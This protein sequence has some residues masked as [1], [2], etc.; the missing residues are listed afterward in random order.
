MR[1]RNTRRLCRVIFDAFTIMFCAAFL[2][3]S[4]AAAAEPEQ[5]TVRVGY[6]NAITYEEKRDDGYMSGAGYEYLQKISYI[7]GWNYEYVYGSF[8]ECYEMLINGDIDLFG[9]LTYTPERAE[10]FSF[11]TYP[12][13]QEVYCMYTNEAHAALEDGGADGLNGCRIG[14]TAG[15]YQQNI[16][17]QWLDMNHVQAE[18]VPLSGYNALMQ[19]L[20]SDQVDTIVTPDLSIAY[21]CIPLMDVGSS[22]YF[23][24]VSKNRPDLLKEL[25]NAQREI[26]RNEFDYN[27]ALSRKYHSQT[28]SSLELSDAE[29]KWLAQR[30][31]Q[32]SIGLLDHNLPYSAQ[33]SNGEAN[34]ILSVLGDTMEQELGVSVQ[35]KFYQN[36]ASLL[37][38]MQNGEVDAIA[39]I[40]GDLYLAEQSRY[41]LTNAI[42]KTTP[43]VLYAGDTFDLDH[44]VIAV[45]DESLITE[46][47]IQILYPGA[48]TYP[49]RNLEDCLNAVVSG[50]A[51]GTVVTSV[52]LNTLRQ[53]PAMEK[54]QFTDLPLEAEICLATTKGNRMAAAVLNTG[55]ALSTASL[56]G[57]MLAQ[58]SYVAPH[59]SLW[60][61]VKD[62]MAPVLTGT[63]AVILVLLCL[64]F[65]LSY[66]SKRLDAALFSA[67]SANDA[68]TAFLNTMSHDM[69]TPLNAI[70]GLTELAQKED[71]FGIVREYLDKVSTSGKFL[72]GLINDL[73]DISKIESGGLKLNPAP[74]TKK[75]FQSTIDTVIKPLMEQR[76]IRFICQLE[77]GPECISVDGLRFEQIF[78]N[79]LSNASK[80]TPEGGE[81][82]FLL[83][84][85]PAADGSAHM[86]FWVRD[87]GVGM[88]PEF[89]ERMYDP[90]A[91]EK[92][93][94]SN[95]TKGTGLGLAIVKKL[96]DAMGGTI[97][98]KSELGKGTEFTVEL[99]APLAEAPT[100]DISENGSS[101][102][103]R[104][105][106]ILLVE[107]NEINT[108]V[109]KLILEEAGCSVTTAENGQ[110]ALDR[111][112]ASKPGDFDAILMDVRMPVMDGLEA[113]RAIRALP[114]PDAVTI[115]II[116][117]TADAF[118][119][120]QKKTM[121][122]GMNAHISKPIDVKLL[123]AVLEKNIRH[124]S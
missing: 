49:C 102:S 99:S 76:N 17:S 23:F 103:L 94:L 97:T 65:Q 87:N 25:N 58:S 27:G 124:E 5:K 84:Q 101:Q 89:V 24:G 13:G 56:N 21:G 107:D 121:D 82:D 96:V 9:N 71:D 39:P 16:L 75:E 116:A 63:T 79:L 22:D 6:V 119:E 70:I 108:Y 11:A 90:F 18:I 72:L 45:S 8:Q 7:T 111:F 117:M 109:A 19:A 41:A 69:R 88:S 77:D 120:E 105:A 74:F 83:E 46:N 52:R 95:H 51:N 48:Q 115:P 50:R 57:S 100:E 42:I 28:N 1:S 40:F 26:Q 64:S 32:V 81:V 20:D 31:N 104:D 113:T 114:R 91:Q 37:N 30:G 93:K 123:Y 53:Y 122:A 60:D 67:Q 47:V 86:R 34:G 3:P 33:A 73:L 55:I 98:V 14:V 36:S 106:K 35:E 4:F 29:I 92:S 68:K 78:Q 54:L 38:A 59:I 80:F 85:L 44:A 2:C 61:F 62:N 10:L 118:A 112:G 15:S 66:K 12:Q 43:V 110:I